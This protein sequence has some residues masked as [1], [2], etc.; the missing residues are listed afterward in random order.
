LTLGDQNSSLNIESTIEWK[1]Q[2]QAATHDAYRVTNQQRMAPTRALEWI[3]TLNAWLVFRNE[4]S[5]LFVLTIKFIS[6]RNYH[7]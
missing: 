7:S 6:H 4:I 3:T 1:C 2:K 5:H